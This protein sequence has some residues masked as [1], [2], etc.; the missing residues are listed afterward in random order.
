MSTS[1]V[2]SKR[3]IVLPGAHPA[4]VFDIQQEADGRFLLVRLER[5]EGATPMSREACL[6]AM[7]TYP[8][9]P[10]ITWEQLSKWTRTP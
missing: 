3:G 10:E 8:F 7:D 6:E 4:D 1:K 5:P 2:D 9:R